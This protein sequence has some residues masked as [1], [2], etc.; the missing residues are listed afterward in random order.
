M[1][2]IFSIAT[3]FTVLCIVTSCDF[4]K[5]SELQDKFEIKVL[6]EPVLSKLNLRVFNANQ[7]EEIP[8]DVKLE[9]TGTN[10]NQILTVDGSK[11]FKVASGFITL[12][13]NKD[14][15]V[16]PTNPLTVTATVSADGFISKTRDLIFDGSDISEIQISMLEKA[17]LPDQI[18]LE[19][20]RQTLSG[21]QTTTDINVSITSK[22]NTE[23]VT[24][25]TIPANTSFFDEDDNLITGTNLQADFQT[26]NNEGP[27]EDEVLDPNENP[28][29]LNGGVN[30]FP[31]GLSLGDDISNKSLRKIQQRLEQS[32]LVP[33]TNLWCFYLF[34][35]GRK[36]R[37]FSNPTLVRN[38]IFR[39]AFNP[40]T[41]Q[42]VKVGDIVS[43]YFYNRNTRKKEKLSNATVQRD[44]R[45]FYV[46]FTAPRSGVYPIGFERKFNH[47]CSSINS[48]KFTNNGQRSFYRYTVASKSN[49]NRPIR[50]GY[51]YFN[52]QLEINSN[53]LNYWRYR[54]FS[55]L[56]DDM[57]LKI[58][59][60][61]R[62]QR[63]YKVVYDKEIS[64]CEL[65]G[66]TIDISNDDCFQERDLDLSLACPDATYLLNNV[67]VYFKEENSRGWGYFDRIRNSR[68]DGKSPC[69][70]AGK[71]YQFGFWYSG[72]KITPPLTEAE[73][74]NL[75]E[76]F[77]LPTICKAVK[78]L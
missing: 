16:T 36:V 7:G 64:V 21:N 61:S 25:F 5:A 74:V 76:N 18:Q 51:M 75:Y 68:L 62:Q 50:Y 17:N 48:I 45:G 78:E 73:M 46:E 10:A 44:R 30:E 60:Y 3:I 40:D 42:P 35:N 2:K 49:P 20:V 26:F 59:N 72:W 41:N 47:T 55:S 6:A 58:Y 38:Y 70:E 31:G 19:T 9:L 57:I 8:T 32:Y 12:G 77:D 65:D 34:V 39:N 13:V 71:K 52:G 67:Y 22:I 43:V 33:V 11:E 27:E 1:K 24:E 14:F 69:L 15:V 23:E 29:V 28:E 54:G 56:G 4:E 63:R 53:N 66:Q 37:R